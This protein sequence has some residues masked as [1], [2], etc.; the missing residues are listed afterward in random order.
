MECL[1]RS[2]RVFLFLYPFCPF[3][4]FLSLCGNSLFL[5]YFLSHQKIMITIIITC[6]IMKEMLRKGENLEIKEYHSDIKINRKIN[7]NNTEGAWVVSRLR[8]STVID[9]IDVDRC[10][11]RIWV[12]FP[13]SEA[14]LVLRVSFWGDDVVLKTKSWL[15][16]PFCSSVYHSILSNAAEEVTCVFIRY[17][18][19][20]TTWYTVMYKSL[21][22]VTAA[23]TEG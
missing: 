17:K 6:N 3:C 20:M 13:L 9:L 7:N 12:R 8:G 18:S 5:P 2:C 11:M 4:L 22:Q 19:I 21:V 23:I 10:S 14:D 1:W 15:M 16:C